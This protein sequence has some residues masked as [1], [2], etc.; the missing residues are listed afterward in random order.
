MEW[1][2]PIQ[3]IGMG[4]C[5][6]GRAVLQITVLCDIQGFKSDNQHLKL[7]LQT[8]GH[9]EQ[10][11]FP[12]SGLLM[13]LCSLWRAIFKVTNEN[14]VEM[15]QGTASWFRNGLICAQNKSVQKSHLWVS[16]STSYEIGWNLKLHP[17]A[18]QGNATLSRITDG[19]SLN[20]EDPKN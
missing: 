7:K 1:I 12:H 16:L 3:S 13:F 2:H 20:V 9:P 19:N 15:V 11:M 5:P 14:Y 10:C 18:I 17:I 4:R 6:Q 8:A